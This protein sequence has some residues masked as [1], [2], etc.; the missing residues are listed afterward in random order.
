MTAADES[1]DCAANGASAEVTTSGSSASS[2]L[3]SVK[4]IGSP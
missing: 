3:F 2:G 4:W 1:L